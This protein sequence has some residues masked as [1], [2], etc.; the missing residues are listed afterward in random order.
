MVLKNL[1]KMHK[2][3]IQIFAHRALVDFLLGFLLVLD[4]EKASPGQEYLITMETPSEAEENFSPSFSLKF[5]MH[6]YFRL[7]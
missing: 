2:Y 5:L 7:N 4:P 3:Q 1:L 6:I